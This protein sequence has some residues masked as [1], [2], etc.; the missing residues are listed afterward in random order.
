MCWLNPFPESSYKCMICSA[1][2]RFHSSTIDKLDSD[3]DQE[4]FE[5]FSASLALPET[6]RYVYTELLKHEAHLGPKQCAG[7]ATDSG[8]GTKS[9]SAPKNQ[10]RIIS[11]VESNKRAFD[12]DDSDSD[13][14]TKDMFDRTPSSSCKRR[15]VLCNVDLGRESDDSADDGYSDNMSEEEPQDSALAIDPPPTMRI[16]LGIQRLIRFI[17]V[18]KIFTAPWAPVRFKENEEMLVYLTATHL[19]LITG[20]SEYKQHKT[21]LFSIL[22]T[23]PDLVRKKNVIWITNRQQG[24]TSTLSK[25]LAVLSYLSPVG[26]NFAFVYSTTR[27]KAVDLVDAARKY[28]HWAAT[29]DSIIEQLATY[30]LEPPKFKASNYTTYKLYSATNSIAVNIVK[31]R[32]KSAAYCRGDASETVII[33]EFG[34]VEKQF[35]DEFAFPLTQVALHSR[36]CKPLQ[37]VCCSIHRCKLLL[38]QVAANCLL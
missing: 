16:P 6:T 9:A 31:A 5:M 23:D 30:G 8:L 10:P 36:Y 7:P 37:T 35:W 38:L 3:T 14:S 24:K 29:T 21:Q 2:E 19:K 27:D 13:D 4:C 34:F 1:Q 33:D 25:F 18:L 11:N 20:K 22:G 12:S 32:P 28:L 17:D 26:G 15:R